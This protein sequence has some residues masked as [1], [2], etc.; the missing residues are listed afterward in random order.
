[1]SVL[2]VYEGMMPT[3]NLL[4]ETF[5]PIG[6]EVDD[7]DF[8]FAQLSTVV[9]A[10]INAASSIV[11]I[12]PTNYLACG[13]ARLAKTKGKAVVTYLDDDLLSK[14]IVSLPWRQSALREILSWSDAVVS[15]NRLLCDKYAGDTLQKTGVVLPVAVDMAAERETLPGDG[16]AATTAEPV[17]IVYAANLTHYVFFDK[18]VLPALPALAEEFGSRI[19]FVFIGVRPSF[20]GQ[21]GAIPITFLRSMPFDAYREH[22]KRERYDIGIAP[23]PDSEFHK[24]KYFNKF[25]EYTI[26]GIF[27]IYSNVSPYSLIV[28]NEITGLLVDNTTDAWLAGLRKAIRDAEFRKDCVARAQQQLKERFTREAIRK[29]FSRE[30]LQ[31]QIGAAPVEGS[32]NLSWS[33]A[34]YKLL[35]LIEKPSVAIAYL[36]RGDIDTLKRKIESNLHRS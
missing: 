19:E 2:F 10:M 20:Q 11:F 33:K 5:G 14:Q 30:L 23:L 6:Q 1:M 16:G 8:R 17:R 18:I 12:R 22:M 36:A 28:E 21:Q 32:A 25:I 31:I 27:G 24:Y 3:V 7:A 34:I 13:I 9:E 29:S 35:R 15:P 26:S 4:M